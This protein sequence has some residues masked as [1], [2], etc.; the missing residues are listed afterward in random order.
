MLQVAKEKIQVLYSEEQIQTRIRELAAQID[1]DYQDSDSLV[2]IGVL[3][4]AFVFVADLIRALEINTQVEFIRLS[5]Y[6]DKTQSSGTVRLYDL[7]LP[8]LENRDV[9]LVDDIV[10]S[11]R[12]AKFLLDFVSTQ[13]RARSVK[14]AALFDKPCRRLVELNHIN[15]DYCC[16]N[17]DDK[18][19]L[20][21]GLDFDQK[22]REL[23]YIGY[24]PELA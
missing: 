12:T 13:S 7:S 11:G 22:F 17:V 4:G 10:D 1:N 19:I 9:L 15:P 20:G 21:Y 8:I 3:K 6:E 24:I 2:V 18:F 5:S 14:L 16:F 23:P